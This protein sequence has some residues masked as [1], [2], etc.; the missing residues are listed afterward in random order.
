MNYEYSQKEFEFF[1]ELYQMVSAYSASHPMDTGG[2]DCEK[3]IQGGVEKLGQTPYLKLG[4]SDVENANGLVT[5]MG[6]MEVVAAVSPSLYLTAEYSM[7]LL[8]RALA[9]WGDEK[10]KQ[11][12]LNP[13]ISGS[14]IGALALCEQTVNVD[15]EPLAATGEKQG[16]TV[17]ISG[18]KQFVVNGPVAKVIGV[19]GTCDGKPAIFLVDGDAPGLSINRT[20]GSFGYKGACISEMILENCRIDE[21]RMIRCSEKEDMVS[22]LRL[23]ENQ[24]LTG[25]SLG[26]M[27][28][29][30]ESARDYAKSHKTGGKPI[31]A[32]QEIGFKLAEM[33]T[34]FQT[35]QML[36]IRAAWTAEKQPREAFDL[37][38]CAK[39]FCTESAARVSGEAMN[40]F[41]SSAYFGANP[42][43]HAY[44]CARYGE[45][46]GTSTELSR[47]KIGDAALGIK[48]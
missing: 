33:L 26:L 18:R 6:A 47:I 3:N 22:V 15:N 40:I 21:D 8:G 12:F 38:L 7:R 19:V 45:S 29:S 31:I 10:Q 5:L 11:A 28:A 48:P 46:F 30:F 35:S 1:I 32:Y 44:C 14:A 37:T 39:V 16:S 42:V 20:E 13:L 41:G 23:W 24:I 2:A 25:A 9:K 4:V 43:E 27:R 17:I 36:A 34:L